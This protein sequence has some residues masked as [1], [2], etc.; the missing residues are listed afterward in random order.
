MRAC[1][2][3]AVE[4]TPV[5]LMRQ[6]GRYLPEYQRLH[7]RYGFLTLVK[8]PELAAE[9]T[10]QPLRRFPLDAAILFA[11][12]LL[13]LEAMGLP[14]RFVPG[15]G[16]VLD[17]RLGERR[18]VERLAVPPAREALGY[19]LEAARAVRAELA[20]RP[21]SE[22]GPVP[23]IGF[24]GGPFTL[25]SYAVEGGGSRDHRRTK[26]LLWREPELW[27]ELMERLT[28]LTID[29]LAAQVEAGAQVLQL[30][31][32]WAGA[33]APA[34]YRRAV[35]PWSRR[36]AE[37]VGRLRTPE[38]EPVPLIHFVTPTAGLLELVAEAGG[39][40]I[41]LDWRID[42][43]DARRR[44][45]EGRALQGNLDPLLLVEAPPELLEARVAE[46]LRAAGPRGHVFNL[47][48]GVDPA[49]PPEHVAW[50]VE[51]V[52]RLGPRGGGER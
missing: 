10:L 20:A 8:T 42:P 48:H 15:S 52:H 39:D 37:A 41:G 14:L 44:L 6:A 49:T 18:D 9:V 51:A 13:P 19:V 33:L 27:R 43:G 26:A 25:A 32:S 22:G 24:A 35:L 47:G 12:I 1:R 38:G 5:W 29:Y 28:A 45:G 2:G 46:I 50:L 11:D 3:E 16:P 30:F 17:R 34:E 36:I 21:A 40:V 4:R 31:D 23:L 7:E